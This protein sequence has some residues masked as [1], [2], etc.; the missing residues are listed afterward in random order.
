[1]TPLVRAAL[2]DKVSIGCYA[3]GARPIRYSWMKDGAP[4]NSSSVKILQNFLIVE[5]KTAMEFGVYLCNVSNNRGESVSYEVK[6]E[7]LAICANTNKG[8]K[9]DI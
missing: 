2:G 3:T 6:L 4:I 9:N 8:T 7:Q 5:T 1:M